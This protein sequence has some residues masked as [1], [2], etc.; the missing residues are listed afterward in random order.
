VG[1]G[2]GRLKT[3]LLAAGWAIGAAAVG[4][5]LASTAASEATRG[6]GEWAG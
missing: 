2:G 5:A 6:T 4:R 3:S 1:V